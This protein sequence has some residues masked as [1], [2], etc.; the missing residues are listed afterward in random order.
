MDKENKI[1]QKKNKIAK[2]NSVRVIIIAAAIF[3]VLVAA[4]L[5][6]GNSAYKRSIVSINSA[7]IEELAEHDV[8]IINTSI[9]SRLDMLTK[10]END[11][12]YWSRKDGTP[13]TDLLHTD[14]D[15]LDNADK[16]SLVSDDGFIFSSNNVIENRP[17]IAEVCTSSPD[18]F[19]CRFDNTVDNIPDM[20]REFLLYGIRIK[21]V[22]VQGHACSYLCCFVRPANLENELKMEIYGGQGFS[23]VI[24]ADGNYILNINRSHSFLDRDNFF[25]DFENILDYASVEEFREVLATTTT[26]TARANAK[27]SSKS[28]QEY[29]LVFTPMNDV[30]WYFVSAVPSSVFDAQSRNL[31]RIAGLLLGVVVLALAAVIIFTVRA[32]RQQQELEEKAVTDALNA[33]LQDQ[34]IKLEDALNRAENANRA[35]TT[36]LFNMSHDIRTPMNAIIGFNN[37]ALSHI[38]DK[39][40]V[41]N[42]LKKV[43]ISSRQLLSLINDVLDMARIESGTVKCE[44][45]PADIVES[46]SELMDIVKQSTDKKLNI[47]F[48]FSRIEH[49]FALADHLHMS[50]IFT[51]IISNSVK[52]TPEGGTIS[53]TGIETPVSRDNYYGYD[54]IIEDNGIGMSEEFLEHIYEEFSR[55]KSTTASGVQGTG[56]GMAIT[57]RLIDLLNGTIAI[58]SRLGEGTKT[59]IHLEMEA[60]DPNRVSSET[61]SLGGEIDL[62]LLKDKKVLLVEDNELNREIAEDILTEEGMIVDTAEAGDIAVEKMKNAEVGQYDIILMDIQMPRMN[63]YEAT[64]AIRNLPGTYASTIPIIAMTA[65]AFEEDKQNAFASG[66]NGHLAKPIE[67]PKLMETLSRF[68]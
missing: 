6:M 54:F 44:Y 52:Y 32:R 15:F 39:E 23:S 56:L 12:H 49:K 18:K 11:I 45:E 61:A 17:D 42:S 35:K 5:L 66:M 64:K 58:Q 60:A 21:P 30:D 55:E 51:N 47:N 53:F 2:K 22:E 26:T 68:L 25:E 59:T 63:G 33:K 7:H 41:V 3:V 19:V 57:K 20:R 9:E 48:D 13:I 65:N 4:V 8:T 1:S 38:D 31:L 10:I 27:I 14:S 34:Q 28:S 43:G 46:A 29:Y 67:I 37:M 16:I 40:T 36:F 50:R 62:T 24:D